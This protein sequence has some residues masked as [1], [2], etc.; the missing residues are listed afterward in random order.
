M[1]KETRG[2]WD[3]L[4]EEEKVD[5]YYKHALQKLKDASDGSGRNQNWSFDV[6][7]VNPVSKTDLFN[8]L[9]ITTDRA[10]KLQTQILTRLIADGYLEEVQNQIQT[11]SR[12]LSA[13][14]A[15]FYRV[16]KIPE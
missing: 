1:S 3:K 15:S 11:P 14:M 7:S 12:T 13:R 4:S 16:I 2:A 6:G 10:I 9:G 5:H 8:R